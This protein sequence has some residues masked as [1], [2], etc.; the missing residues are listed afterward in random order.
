MKKGNY[1]PKARARWGMT[2]VDRLRLNA[3]VWTWP[4]EVAVGLLSEFEGL[5]FPLF[6]AASD[7]SQG[8]WRYNPS[9]G[10]IVWK[11]VWETIVEGGE[12]YIKQFNLGDE[13]VYRHM[14]FR[15]F[16]EGLACDLVLNDY[17][18]KT[19]GEWGVSLP[20]LVR[21]EGLISWAPPWFPTG[22]ADMEASTYSL[23]R[24]SGIDP[25]DTG[26]ATWQYAGP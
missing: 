24:A 23:L 8:L 9:E 6:I 17:S 21:F 4:H 10:W 11:G 5:P 25:D 26:P 12:W 22:H 19:H 13:W 1:W 14:I 3:P 16:R 20:A 15:C 7:L 18:V 2:D